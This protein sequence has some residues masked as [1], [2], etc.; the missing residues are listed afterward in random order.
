MTKARREAE[1]TT[2][3]NGFS[4]PMSKRA[5]EF[6]LRLDDSLD[7]VVQALSVDGVPLQAAPDNLL[8]VNAAIQLVLQ[9]VQD[10]KSR[11]EATRTKHL[12]AKVSRFGWSFV[13]SIEDC[14]GRVGH[15]DVSTLRAQE[16][17]YVAH[18]RDVGDGG[19]DSEDTPKKGRWHNK[20][21]QRKKKA[22][23]DL[24]GTSGGG[25]SGAKGKGK[26]KAKKKG[27]PKNGCYR[28]GGPHYV[29]ECTAPLSS[30]S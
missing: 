30:S 10:M 11:T 9:A 7:D 27:P 23:D 4:N 5:V 16:K 29:G 22:A 21:Q 17:A 1:I 25:V 15:I 24:K 20:N 19:A 14:E 8:Q 12:V 3:V 28:C 18:R 26:G 13:S 6:T 2:T